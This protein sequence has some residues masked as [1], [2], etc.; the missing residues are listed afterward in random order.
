MLVVTSLY[1]W[2]GGKNS[3][4]KMYCYSSIVVLKYCRTVAMLYYSI[5]I[6][7]CYENVV[8]YYCSVVVLW[9]CCTIVQ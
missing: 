8:L 2:A 4:T 1:T 7:W 6:F 5:V 3:R 9:Q